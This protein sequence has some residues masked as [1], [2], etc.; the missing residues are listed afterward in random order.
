MRAAED[1]AVLSRG[2]CPATTGPQT[3]EQDCPRTGAPTSQ[4]P[5]RLTSFLL[6]YFR[7][8]SRSVSTNFRL[9]NCP[10]SRPRFQ[11]KP[12]R[13]PGERTGVRQSTEQGRGHHLI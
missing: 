1:Q 10:L 9:K 8:P 13:Y 3:E 6:K 12:S 7:A 2:Q 5:D 4:P 11:R